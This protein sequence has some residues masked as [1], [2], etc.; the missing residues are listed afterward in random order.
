M[1]LHE[2]LTSSQFVTQ[3]INR[4]CTNLKEAILYPSPNSSDIT[5]FDMYTIKLACKL[6]ERQNETTHTLYGSIVSARRNLCSQTMHPY[7][8]E[9]GTCS[10][11]TAS[12]EMKYPSLRLRKV[13]FERGAS[14]R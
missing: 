5:L 3:S 13:C 12:S 4:N 9:Q 11:F 14:A 1:S 10:L 7:G 2:P 8:V 6:L